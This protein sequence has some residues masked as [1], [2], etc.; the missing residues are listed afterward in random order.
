MPAGQT[1]PNQVTNPSIVGNDKPSHTLINQ[2]TSSRSRTQL[3]AF[4]MK[5]LFVLFARNQSS[6]V[7]SLSEKEWNT[8]GVK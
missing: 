5:Q 2:T 7:N 8:A 3:L 1:K 6:N 4:G